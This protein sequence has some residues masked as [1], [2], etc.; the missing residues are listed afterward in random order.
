[1]TTRLRSGLR[2]FTVIPSR[3][4]SS[5]SLGSASAT[6]FCT[7]TCALS[8]SVPGLKVTVSTIDPSLVDCEDRYSM[9][10]TPFTSCSMGVATVS[11][12]TRALAPG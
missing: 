4:T 6:R 1:L 5:G 11:M 2:F 12:T 7:S 10:S 8:M 9:S 3:R